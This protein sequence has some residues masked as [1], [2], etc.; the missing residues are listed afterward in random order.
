MKKSLTEHAAYELTKS[1]LANNEDAEARQTAI[2]IMAIVRRIEKQKNS[3]AQVEFMLETLNR[4]LN[5]L[6]MTAI[7]DDPEEWDQYVLKRYVLD[8]ETKEPVGDPEEQSVWQAKRA[9]HIVSYTEGKTWIDQATGKSGQSLDHI[10]EAKRK[11]EESARKVKPIG[12]VDPDA[13]AG[14]VAADDPRNGSESAGSVD[15]SESN[16]NKETE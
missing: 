13:P 9:E 14:E 11:E 7:T 10:E 8:P 12:H 15:K 2:N 6:P 16:V 1:G 4:L 3:E 5:G